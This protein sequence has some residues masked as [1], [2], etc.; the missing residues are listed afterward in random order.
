MTT[1]EAASKAFS[2][3]FASKIPLRK[4]PLRRGTIFDDNRVLQAEPAILM[5]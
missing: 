3:L 1:L 4:G 2:V 5:A